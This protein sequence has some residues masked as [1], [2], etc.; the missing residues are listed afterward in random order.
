MTPLKCEKQLYTSICLPLSF[1]R[2]KKEVLS[3]FHYCLISTMPTV[4]KE[5]FFFTSKWHPVV[6]FMWGLVKC[7]VYN[8]RV[9]P[10]WGS[11]LLISVKCTARCLQYTH[12]WMISLSHRH[13]ST[14]SYSYFSECRHTHTHTLR[15]RNLLY[16]WISV[17]GRK[18]NKI[19]KG[20]WL[21][22]NPVMLGSFMTRFWI[23]FYISLW[24]CV[25]LV[26]RHGWIV[27]V[28]F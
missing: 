5:P 10:K 26:S 12:T 14:W 4:C 3:P 17:V 23:I 27:S 25:F 18:R 19:D 21:H 20:F 16:K 6:L 22:V 8:P 28:L 1:F 2:K 24:Y 9:V 15:Q 7:R 11:C 13:S